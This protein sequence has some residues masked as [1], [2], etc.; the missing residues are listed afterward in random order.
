MTALSASFSL[1]SGNTFRYEVDRDGVVTEDFNRPPTKADK[2]EA[3]LKVPEALA[4]IR[5]EMGDRDRVRGVP[6]DSQVAS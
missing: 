4:E 2:A 3:A 1:A 6:D 5:A